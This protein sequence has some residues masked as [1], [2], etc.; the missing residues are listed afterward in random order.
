MILNLAD[1]SGRRPDPVFAR[2]AARLRAAGVPLLGYVDA[3][4]EIGRHRPFRT[5]PAMDPT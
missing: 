3:A 5:C 2:T 1:G 4:A